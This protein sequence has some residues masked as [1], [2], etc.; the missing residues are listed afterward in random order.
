VDTGLT[1]LAIAYA[2]FFIALAGFLFRIVRRDG[3]L[4]ASVDALEARA[5][6]DPPG[7]Q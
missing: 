5:G 4:Q 3:E 2:G 1:Y 7:E 6:N